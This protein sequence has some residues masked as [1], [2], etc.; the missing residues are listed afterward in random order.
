MIPGVRPQAE[1]AFS[2]LSY[3][4]EGMRN[5]IS[6]IVKWLPSLA[7]VGV[8]LYT[9]PTSIA[10]I[11]ST[12]A[13]T[14]S[15][16][17]FHPDI[18]RS[19]CSIL[20]DLLS[21][22]AKSTNTTQNSEARRRINSDSSRSSPVGAWHLEAPLVSTQQLLQLQNS[23][24]QNVGVGAGHSTDQPANPVSG[25]RVSPGD[26]HFQGPLVLTQQPLQ[27]Q[28]PRGQNVGVGAGHSTDQTVNRLSG[29]SV[30]VRGGHFQQT[31]NTWGEYA[32]EVPSL[33]SAQLRVPVGHRT[34]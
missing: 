31:P 10:L 26:G 1:N 11:F 4:S 32:P 27:L 25:Q 5:T 9:L 2:F 17:F 6:K 24:R 16:A 15:A 13:L 20:P 28:N 33:Q 22:I 34:S 21:V 12:V 3:L 29:R 14:G 8:A 18:A 19:L 23:R 7:F 30:S